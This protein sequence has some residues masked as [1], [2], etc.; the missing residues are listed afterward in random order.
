MGAHKNGVNFFKVLKLFN[1]AKQKK[2]SFS[3]KMT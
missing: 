2:T 1:Q 3:Q